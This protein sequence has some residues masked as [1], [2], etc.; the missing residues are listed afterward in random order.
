MGRIQ[1]EGNSIMNSK[2]EAELQKFF[3]KDIVEFLD[4]KKALKGTN[5][6][7]IEFKKE[8]NERNHSR[9]AEILED[10]VEKF[11]QTNST[12]VYREIYFNEI[13]DM[14][15]F[16]NQNINKE[17]K[18]RLTENIEM[19]QKSKQLEQDP[20]LN[21]KV[22]EDRR[23]QEREKEFNREEKIRDRANIIEN[24]MIE[25]NKKLFVS[26]RKKDL[27]NAIS[28]YKELKAKFEQY[29][30]SLIEEK[31]ELYNDLIAFFMRI[32][33][34][35]EELKAENIPGVQ[36][37]IIQKPKPPERILKIEEIKEIV[38]EVKK[39]IKETEFNEAKTKIIH[40]KHT[41][42]LIPEKYINIK[43]KLDDIANALMQ[44]TEFAKNMHVNNVQKEGS[45]E[46]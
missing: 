10:A 20:S 13:I 25:I 19:L 23:E 41:I 15:R 28:I 22:F 44:K 30:S 11:N 39:N 8:I 12:D 14:V 40:L 3:E 26:I 17:N 35:K 16:A 18:N 42:S 27:Q 7:L 6:L 34:L 31:T 32:K 9:A 33:T 37:A 24:E 36:E 2:K 1:R 4:R 21:I 43:K 38:E 5:D 46:N 45:Y 29:P